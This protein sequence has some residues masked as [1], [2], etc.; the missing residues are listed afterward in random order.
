MLIAKVFES[1][2]IN[3]EFSGEQLIAFKDGFCDIISIYDVRRILTSGFIRELEYLYDKD[4]LNIE[5][6][7]G[8]NVIKLCEINNDGQIVFFSKA[9]LLSLI[10]HTSEKYIS[11]SMFAEK[12]KVSKS[13]VKKKAQS[14]KIAGIIPIYSSN[15]NIS[16][17]IVPEDAV[18][19]A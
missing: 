16:A 1:K 10:D 3:P 6:E 9:F 7:L 4:I 5:L 17:Y 13:F 19:E 12:N 2:Y 15:G 8:E 14:G 11:L 18:V